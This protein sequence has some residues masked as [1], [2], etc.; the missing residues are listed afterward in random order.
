MFRS[1][2]LA[3]LRSLTPLAL[4]LLACCAVLCAA[5]S[6][7]SRRCISGLASESAGVCA[8]HAQAAWLQSGAQGRRLDL[9]RSAQLFASSDARIA[10]EL[11]SHCDVRARLE[12]GSVAV[13]ARDLRG[14]QLIVLT[15]HGEVVV[16]GT[17]FE[18][19]LA[20][21]PAQVRASYLRELLKSVEDL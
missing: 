12:R 9:G 10:H 5:D 6:A 17:F 1:S 16:K 21:N 18:V 3:R 15:P 13:H 11:S 14:G 20:A 2:W 4:A 8:E 7:G 19:S